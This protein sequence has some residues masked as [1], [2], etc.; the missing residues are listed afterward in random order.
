MSLRFALPLAAVALTLGMASEIN[1]QDTSSLR[2]RPAQMPVA[3][4]CDNLLRAVEIELP[5]AAV[6]VADARK[7][8][9]EAQELCNSG[10]PD[11]GIPILRGILNSVQEGG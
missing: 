4:R 7:D 10:R 9:Q 8:Y 3:S 2:V 6:G 5:N 1:A 11:E